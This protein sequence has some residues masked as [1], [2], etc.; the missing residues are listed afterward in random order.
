MGAI[1]QPRS[2]PIPQLAS[3]C[4]ALIRYGE[5]FRQDGGAV[6]APCS[7]TRW[8]GLRRSRHARHRHTGDHPRGR[9]LV[10]GLCVWS[11]FDEAFDQPRRAFTLWLPFV[12]TSSPPCVHRVYHT[13][14]GA[15]T[16][17]FGRG[18][19]LLHFVA[20]ILGPEEAL[21]LVF[22]GFFVVPRFGS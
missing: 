1:S 21:V 10:G 15:A 14:A 5:P 20:D 16:L 19:V 7:S 9:H 4:R 6:L 17:F 11:I 8:S 3:P 13:I 18:L 12:E 22:L 2:P